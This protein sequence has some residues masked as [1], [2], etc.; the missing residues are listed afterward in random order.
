MVRDPAEFGDDWNEPLEAAD[1]AAAEGYFRS[2]ERLSGVID[3]V[4][5]RVGGRD[6]FITWANASSTGASRS[7][8][9]G[10]RW[11]R[12]FSTRSSTIF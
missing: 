11:S 3:F 10:N 7:K 5:L 1:V 8:C 2:I 4:N 6:N 12:P 9:R